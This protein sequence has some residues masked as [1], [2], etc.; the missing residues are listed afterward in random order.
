LHPPAK[1]HLVWLPQIGKQDD[2]DSKVP[3][4]LAFWTKKA[5]EGWEEREGGERQGRGSFS[6]LFI[7]LLF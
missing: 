7:F 2:D 4:A 6:L 1:Q 5:E 3:S